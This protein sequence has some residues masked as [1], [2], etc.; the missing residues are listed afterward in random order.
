MTPRVGRIAGW[1]RELRDPRSLGAKLVVIL[2]GVGLAG[3]LGVTIMLVEVIT[4]SFDQLERQAIDGHVERTH[5]TL[6]EFV[7]KVE[8]SVR[9]YGDWN[10][11]YAYMEH[12]TATFERESFS[13]L[14]MDN[15]EVNGMAYVAPDGHVVIARWHGASGDDVAMR[16]AFVAQIARVDFRRIMA[17]RSSSSFFLRIGREVDA[18]AV[19]LVRKSDGSGTPHGLVLMARRLTSPQLSQLLQLRAGLAAAGGDQPQVRNDRSSTHIAVPILGPDGHAVAS[20][21]FA[22][23]RD[24]SLLG[25]R[26]L[27]LAVAGTV[28][29]LVLVLAILKRMITRLVLRPLARVEQHMTVVRESGALA[30]LPEEQRQDEIGAL[31]KSFNRMLSQLRD[32]QEQ[33][34]VQSFALGKSESAVAVMHNVRNALNPISTILSQGIAQ[35]S[36]VDPT[37]LARAIEELKRDDLPPPRRDK[38]VAFLA[39]AT[40]AE[41]QAREDRRRQLQA[42]R[43][44]MSHVLEIIGEQ[45]HAAHQRP[46]LEACDATDIVARNAAIARYAE[47]L[48]IAFVFPSH[49]HLVMASRLIL[50]QVIGNLIANAAEAIAATGEGGGTITAEIGDHADGRTTISIRDTGDGFDPANAPELFQRG[51]STRRHKSGGLGLHWCANSMTAMGG[52]LTLTSEGRGWGAVATLTLASAAVASA[53]EAKAA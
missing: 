28:V 17:G 33:V 19:A 39:A 21:R 10:D 48:S 31:G 42:G 25:L 20:A 4:P 15:L 26:M 27:L 29:L 40:M 35:P 1:L 12:Q 36:P 43:E 32:L 6:R 23:P 30:T 46:E 22:V 38:L 37:V 41:D 34:E 49:P 14:A 18:V 47:G 45:Q 8:N 7:A 16:N 50:S 5:A 3:S 9:D 53:G 2:L 52:T 13:P 44:A 11:S 24:I 51:F